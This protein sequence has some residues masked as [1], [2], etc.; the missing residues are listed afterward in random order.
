MGIL[1]GLGDLGLGKLENAQIIDKSSGADKGGEDTRGK[2]N[3]VT[4]DENEVLFDKSCICPVCEKKFT[5]RAVRTGKARL[6]GM[7]D[8]LRP[9]YEKFDPLKYDVI[10]CTGCGYAA[11]SKYFPTITSSQIKLINEQ[12]AG[13]VHG[14]NNSGIL[15]YD[16]AIARHQLALAS[17]MVK[18]GKNSERAFI[19]L[20]MAWCLRGKRETYP[21]DAEDYESVVENCIKDEKEALLRAF[22]GFVHAR[23]TESFPIAGMDETTLD[24][25]IAELAFSQ[26]ETDISSRLV[27]Q[28]L[29]NKATSARIK[30][31][32]RD[33]KERI[34]KEK[35]ETERSNL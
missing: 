23:Q 34:K 12:I 18:K 8:D 29:V 16:D 19:C 10:V 31:K 14:V 25:L 4:F 20:K 27:S 2:G 9:K 30:D 5:Y 32:C 11:L 17:S 26:G 6:I 33:L 35:E 15:S 13:R 22:E 21:T 3:E 24:Y 28:L 1:S 7:D